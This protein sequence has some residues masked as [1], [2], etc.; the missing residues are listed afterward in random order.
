[1]RDTIRG[2]IV[3]Y[4]TSTLCFCQ[5]ISSSKAIFILKNRVI[6]GVRKIKPDVS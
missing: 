1:M 5:N 4:V 6:I 2:Y 3:E